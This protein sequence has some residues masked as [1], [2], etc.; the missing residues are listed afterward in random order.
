[1]YK[2]GYWFVWALLN[3]LGE[4]LLVKA[5]WIGYIQWDSIRAF[6]YYL[7]FFSAIWLQEYWY[8]GTGR[9]R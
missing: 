7:S 5:G 1:M 9:V 3:T 2:I 4:L 6:I 8:N